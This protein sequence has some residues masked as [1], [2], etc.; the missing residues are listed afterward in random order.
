MRELPSD[1]S[2]AVDHPRVYAKAFASAMDGREIPDHET[3]A[4]DDI[5]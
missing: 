5:L 1:T 2:G 3:P 4:V